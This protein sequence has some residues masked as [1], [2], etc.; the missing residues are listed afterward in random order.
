[1]LTL[2]II[3]VLRIVRVVGMG[4]RLLGYV[5]LVVLLLILLILGLI[6]VLTIVLLLAC[7]L[8]LHH[9]GLVYQNAII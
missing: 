3:N 1:M 8:M 2:L 7:I 9:Q 5:R 6:C 4:I